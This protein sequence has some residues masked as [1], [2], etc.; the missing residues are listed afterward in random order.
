MISSPIWVCFGKIATNGLTVIFIEFLGHTLTHIY[1]I[2]TRRQHAPTLYG[3]VPIDR[4]Y[5]IW[6]GLM[7]MVLFVVWI[8]VN[9]RLYSNGVDAV[10]VCLCFWFWNKYHCYISLLLYVTLSQNKRT[11]RT[12]KQNP[13]CVSVSRWI[14][15]YWLGSIEWDT[16]C[17]M[18]CFSNTWARKTN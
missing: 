17:S 2:Q 14:N 12:K 10:F 18:F 15:S 8:F 13:L 3:C 16:E 6:I 5:P 4:L 9:A 11:R 7:M 1:K